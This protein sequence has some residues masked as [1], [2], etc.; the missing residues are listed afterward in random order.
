MG[1]W[2]DGARR[3]DR[4]SGRGVTLR[5][6]IV[7]GGASGAITAMH[8]MRG[9]RCPLHITIFDPSGDPGPG[10][11]HGRAAPEHLLNVPAGRMGAFHDDPT[12]FLQ[13]LRA[14]SQIPAWEDFLPRLTYG[15]YLR[16]RLAQTARAAGPG[17]RLE[18][19]P[20]AVGSVR[21][22]GDGFAV[23][24][25]DG[26]GF[27]ADRLV[28]ATGNTAPAPL[29]GIDPELAAT[30]GYIPDPWAAGALAEIGTRRRVLLVGTGLTMV[31]V[32]LTL[33]ATGRRGVGIEAVS[34]HGLLPRAHRVGRR[35]PGMPTRPVPRTAVELT[36]RVRAHVRATVAAGGDWRGGIDSLR[37]A[38]PDLW[39]ALPTD[40][41]ARLLRHAGRHWEVH[42]HRMAPELDRRL[43]SLARLGLLRITRARV[44]SAGP[45]GAGAVAVV[46][47]PGAPDV[48]A[49]RT[50]DVVVNCTGP[51]G[52]IDRVCPPVLA[53]MRAEGM[54]RPD[55]LHLSIDTD[56]AGRVI[57]S[58]GAPVPG[59]LAVGPLRRGEGWETTAIPEIR[60]HGHQVAT[61][62]L[63]DAD[64]L[65]ASTAERAA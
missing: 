3:N 53:Q 26:R 11:A 47:T 45:D 64:R 30:G 33:T 16:Q 63:A 34:R 35:P 20:H 58:D 8:L 40:E 59:L 24:T 42:R 56:A 22:A 46:L 23:R 17:V 4:G 21:R 18:I 52:D 54:L 14:H 38:T 9:A 5:V 25:G 43:R 10:L 57:G 2:R 41:R 61:A 37:A 27:H 12:D 39:R 49:R 7:G 50:V 32:A 48:P 19:V 44:A 1:W 62:I 65:R 15:A 6:A 31:D 60:R 13:W 28:L 51:C 29:P 36:R 55:P